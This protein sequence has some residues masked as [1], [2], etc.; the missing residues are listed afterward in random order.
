MQTTRR[1][2]VAGSLAASA[3]AQIQGSNDRLRV[4]V[5]GCGI[6]GNAHLKAL[7]RIKEQ[8]NV[9]VAA[10]CD[11]FQKRADAASQLTGGKVIK[12]YRDLM[13][14]KDLDYILI[15]TPEHWHYQMLLDGLPA[16][17]HIYCEKPMTHTVEQAKHITGKINE[18][19]KQKVQIGVQGMSDDSYETANKYVKEGAL[20]KVVIAQIDYARNHKDDFWAY[21]IDPDAK[22][23]ENLDWK[24]WLGPAPKRPS[25]AP[26]LGLLRRHRDRSLHSS[27][28]T[29]HQ[30]A[31]LGLSRARH[32]NRR[33][34]R[35]HRQLGGNSRYAE[36]HA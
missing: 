22:P 18:A 17:K 11:V 23:G 19:T 35:V 13:S 33:Q 2:F 28:D 10:V 20:G 1:T 3:Y 6:Q 4:G 7:L 15:A 36:R 14:S 12:D 30:V 27:S 29:D 21:D 16:G 5:I 26:L 34:V 8:D 9:E 24:Q 31:E 25:M 32:G